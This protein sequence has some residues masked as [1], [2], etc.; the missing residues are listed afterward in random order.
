MPIALKQ[1]LTLDITLRHEWRF[2][3]F[4]AG[5][6]QQVVDKLININ[7]DDFCYFLWGSQ[8]SGKTHLLNALCQSFQQNRNAEGKKSYLAYFSLSEATPYPAEILEGLENY[9]LV[10]IDNIDVIFSNNLWELALFNL[11]NQLRENGGI[12]VLSASKSLSESVINLADL[13]SRLS[14]GLIFQVKT[15][16]DENKAQVLQ[17]NARERGIKLEAD[18]IDFILNR[19]P[20]SM[21]GLISLLDTIDKESLQQKRLITIPFLKTLFS[22]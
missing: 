21:S 17:Q 11:F 8:G 7:S 13:K 1:Q 22:W 20:R 6:N 3:N 2:D 18:V 9:P 5:D 10:C 15:L 14:S 12:L 19:G 4:I 16:S